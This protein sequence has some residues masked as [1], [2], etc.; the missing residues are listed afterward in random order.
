VLVFVQY[1]CSATYRI[2]LSEAFHYLLDQRILIEQIPLS[3]GACEQSAQE[4]VSKFGPSRIP[5]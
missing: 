4:C 5:L 2:Q 1:A 3:F